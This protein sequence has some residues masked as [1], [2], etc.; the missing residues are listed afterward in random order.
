MFPCMFPKPKA[1][2]D[3]LYICIRPSANPPQLRFVGMKAYP[4]I[5]YIR[6]AEENMKISQR[7]LDINS[8]HRS[9]SSQ[10]HE[11]IF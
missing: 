5:L 7:K 4:V 8:V 9:T 2:T 6:L 10:S 11:H 1:I 3:L